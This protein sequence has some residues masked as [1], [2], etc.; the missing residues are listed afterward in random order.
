MAAPAGYEEEAA[1]EALEGFTGE[2][3]RRRVR[4]AGRC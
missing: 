4:A 3:L 1:T 2:C